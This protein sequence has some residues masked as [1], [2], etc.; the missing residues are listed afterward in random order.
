[1]RRVLATDRGTE[2]YAHRQ[3]MVEP[4]F[5]QIKSNRAAPTASAA[6]ADQESDPSGGY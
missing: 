3:A 2:P 6:V 5:G 4:V 1:M